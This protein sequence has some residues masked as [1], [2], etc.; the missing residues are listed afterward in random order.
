[1][2]STLRHPGWRHRGASPF[3]RVD[4]LDDFVEESERAETVR[5]PIASSRDEW[6]ENVGIVHLSFEK[7]DKSNRARQHLSRFTRKNSRGFPL[8]SRKSANALQ[9][10]DFE[11][12]RANQKMRVKSASSSHGCPA[13]FRGVPSSR[14]GTAAARRTDALFSIRSSEQPLSVNDCIF[15]F[16]VY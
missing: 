7:C 11:V 13:V 6:W 12:N 5:S 15:D 4:E 14:A 2:P 10:S 1:V 9:V 16:C 3:V 8:F